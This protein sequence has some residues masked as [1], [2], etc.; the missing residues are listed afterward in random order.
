M[1]RSRVVRGRC[2]GE[3]VDE[4]GGVEEGEVHR[5]LSGLLVE[6]GLA[7]TEETEGLGFKAD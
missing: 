1:R 3:F 6:A 4:D 7:G 5:W 2:V